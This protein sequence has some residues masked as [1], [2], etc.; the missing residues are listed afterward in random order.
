MRAFGLSSLLLF[1]I[2]SVR[3]EQPDSVKLNE[4][5]VSTARAAVNPL[6]GGNLRVDTER[7]RRGARVM[8][9]ADIV[10][11]LKRSAAITT[12]S[13]YGS[14]LS[15]RGN[16]ASH[17][18]FRL[19]NAPVFFPY[20]FGGVFSTFNTTHFTSAT[21]FQ[22][23]RGAASPSRLGA[24]IDL[25]PGLDYNKPIGGNLNVGLLAST[26][27]LRSGIHNK[28]AVAV[29][30]RV[31]YIDQL[32]GRLLNK[33]VNTIQ[34]RFNDLNVSA[35]WR[36]DSVNTITL[37]YFRNGDN[38]SSGNANYS[39]NTLLNWRNNVGSIS[40][41][42]A[43]E[44]IV[45]AYVSEF[46]SNLGVA[47]PQND[48]E[49]HNG[50]VAYGVT[51]QGRVCSRDKFAV[52]A[53]GDVSGMRITP[54]WAYL[55]GVGSH[56][57]APERVQNCW[58]ARAFADA[59]IYLRHGL[60]VNAGLSASIFCGRF[61]A[62]DPRASVDWT[63]GGNMWSFGAGAF[64]QY[65]HQVGFSDLGL[66]SNFWYGSSGNIKPQR[67]IDLSAG[68]QRSF[69]SEVLLVSASVY[70]KR[71]TGQTEYQGQVL[72]IIN[73]DYDP[74]R[75]ILISNGYNC[76]A[77]VEVQKRFGPLTGRIN[78][79]YGYAIRR[80][81]GEWFRSLTDAGHQLKAD[82]DY[83]FNSHWSVGAAFVFASG[84]VYTP[85]RYLYVI[86]NRIMAQYG[87]RNSSRFP[88]YQHLDLSATYRTGRHSVNLSVINVYGYRNV[89]MQY[90]DVDSSTGHY[91]L[92]R[93]YSLYRF[94]PS[95]SYS[96]DF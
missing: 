93:Q 23:N 51:G 34:Y 60:T 22:S 45:T 41:R 20:R 3:A 82:V 87:K 19:D 90:F 95:I 58:E 32:Y 57:S 80:S 96:S 43:H 70:F 2:F 48:V 81:G 1:S 78:Y 76:G 92:C 9:E 26:V 28:F 8:G 77:T 72:D 29:S 5:T 68:W 52:V 31:S 88:P 14:G 6:R 56:V 30:G 44:S 65:L 7:L 13:D 73:S 62:V 54:L 79:A 42:G 63:V 69:F 35:G 36:V 11:V 24:V 33:D 37:N 61:F 49:G 74:A 66:A 17:T 64:S 94:L 46:K 50:I 16:D 12:A 55:I 67:S 89:E 59:H 40:W 27:T 39:M 75:S 83:E 15:I 47:L 21:I 25:M 71:V 10:N 18:V 53:G 85:T 38:L 86:S 84:R 4:V 91:S